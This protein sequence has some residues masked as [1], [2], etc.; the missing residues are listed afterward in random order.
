MVDTKWKHQPVTLYRP[1]FWRAIPASI[2]PSSGGRPP[3]LVMSWPATVPVTYS[4]NMDARLPPGTAISS[5]DMFT[6]SSDHAMATARIMATTLA[7][8]DGS[9]S[10]KQLVEAEPS[11]LLTPAL[12]LSVNCTRAS[13][14]CWCSS[15]L[16]FVPFTS[17]V[18][19]LSA[20]SFPR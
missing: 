10:S 17:P 20:E 19:V 4:M 8:I 11:P 12:Q 15:W 7:A 2:M 5:G 18:I 3:T 14:W 9:R 1:E 16:H 13:S 6:Y